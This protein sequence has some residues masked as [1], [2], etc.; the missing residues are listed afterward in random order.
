MPR[1]RVKGKIHPRHPRGEGQS[2]RGTSRKMRQP[3]RHGPQRHR[4]K[5]PAQPEHEWS[6]KSPW[7][8]ANHAGPE[9][10][11]PRVVHALPTHHKDR[12]HRIDQP[13]AEPDRGNPDPSVRLRA[14]RGRVHT[15]IVFYDP[16]KKTINAAN[17]RNR[18]VAGLSLF[19]PPEHT[20]PM[21]TTAKTVLL[22]GIA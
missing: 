10:S 16:T 9:Q 3:C 12:L 1:I 13:E 18:A 21:I 14:S 22:L 4:R 6:R 7:N 17:R 19:R 2:D 8:P 15:E 5:P 11:H 20:V